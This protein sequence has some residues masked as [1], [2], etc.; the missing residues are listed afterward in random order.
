MRIVAAVLSALLV[1]VAAIPARAAAPDTIHV[2]RASPDSFLF[3]LLD[4]GTDAH[5]WDRVNLKPVMSAFKSDAQQQQAFVAGELDFGL[6]SGPAMGYRSK[7]IPAMAVAEMY[8]SPSNMC[9][10]VAQNSPIKT[11]RDLKGKTITVSSAGS[12]TD[13]LVHETSR[14]QGWGNDGITSLEMGAIEPRIIAMNAGQTAGA[15][16][17]LSVGYRVEETHEG[18]VL[19]SFGLIKHFITHAVFAS[20]S[21]IANHPDIVQRFLR[22]WFMTVAYARSHKAETVAS[23]VAALHQSPAVASRLY[24]EELPGLSNNGAFDTQS[25][26][27]VAASLKELGIMDSVPD[28]KTLYTTRFTPVKI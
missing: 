7:G 11:P 15:V 24:D 20:D 18:R 17:D 27:A 5:I 21:M 4:L 25:V 16:A 22:G 28:P 3:A 6:G 1:L 9:V 12:L 19:M 10:I 26:A 23:A 13:W 14:E 8:G 2:G